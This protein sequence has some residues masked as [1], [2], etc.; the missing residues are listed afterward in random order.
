MQRITYLVGSVNGREGALETTHFLTTSLGLTEAS[1]QEVV[2][3]I[4]DGGCPV[5]F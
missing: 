2:L 3:S 4:L 1:A 5:V